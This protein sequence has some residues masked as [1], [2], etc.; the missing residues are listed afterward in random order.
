[1]VFGFGVLVISSLRGFGLI[2]KRLAA[3]ILIT[4]SREASGAEKEVVGLWLA[5]ASDGFICVTPN[6]NLS[7]P[8]QRKHKSLDRFLESAR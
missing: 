8:L 5:S 4:R 7:E 1:M 2:I 3:G 6:H